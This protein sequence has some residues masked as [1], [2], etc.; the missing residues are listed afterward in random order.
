MST[1]QE[2]HPPSSGRRLAAILFADIVGYTALMQQGEGTAM[3]ILNRFQEVTTAKVKNHQGEII[4]T[5]G[6]G[7]LILFDS[8][9]DAVNC[10]HEMQLVFRQG[11]EV[12]LRI[13]IH[14][15]EVVRKDN[16]VFGNGVNI[17]ARIESMGV[18]GGVLMSSDV[19]R[20]I[21]NQEGLSTQPLGQF[22][23]KNV[24]EPIEVYALTN[25]GMIVPDKNKLPGK[26]KRTMS[27]RLIITSL[28]T[29]FLL[30]S[31]AFWLSNN[32]KVERTVEMSL[33]QESGIASLAVLPFTNMSSGQENQYFCDGLHDDLLTHL[34]QMGNTKVISRTSVLRY[35]D[36]EKPIPEIASQLGV[37]H[38][39][40]GSFR[41][42]DNQIRVNVQL[43]NAQSDDHV[44]SEIYDRELN[45][46][47]VFNIQTE[48]TKKIAAALNANLTEGQ[49]VA[50]EDKPTSSL[51][52]YE[53]YLKGRQIMAKRNTPSLLAAKELFEKA[54]SLDPEYAQAL[55]QLGTVHHLM[56]SYSDGDVEDN[57]NKSI[58][59]LDRGLKLHPNMPEAYALKAIIHES[60]KEFDQAKMAFEKSIQLNPNQAITYHWY[61]LFARDI[62][63]DYEKAKSLLEK[64]RELDPLS[65]AINYTLGR[66]HLGLQEF[67]RG[68][69]FLKK[70]IEIEP[71]YP[72]TYLVL[73][74]LYIA[75]NRLDSAALL[76]Y[77]N[78]KTN[79]NQGI[80]FEHSMF[81]FY[82]LGMDE[83]LL[84]EHDLFKPQ[85][86]Q[87]SIIKYRSKLRT[88]IHIKKDLDQAQ[89]F[90][91]EN[92]FVS[93][94]Q[95]LFLRKEWKAYNQLYEKVY[96]MVISL[97][98]VF[99]PTG[100]TPG[101][102]YYIFQQYLFALK[103]EGRNSEYED[104]W[105]YYHAHVAIDNDRLSWGHLIWKD[106]M[107][108]RRASIQNNKTEAI[109]KLKTIR[110][111]GGFGWTWRLLKMD[112]MLEFIADDE[113]YI[114]IM[115]DW[116][117]L[118]AEQR[119]T[120]R[121]TR[122]EI[123]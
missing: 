117:Q 49:R 29:L 54:I 88:F 9:V 28:L 22:D 101:W 50:V 36:T 15:G 19:Q 68:K 113:S 69:F 53:A 99:A 120:V 94:L 95:I 58:D 43:I 2:N 89:S 92:D 108:L 102:D 76:S 56:I 78:L 10:A 30:A 42:A 12:P 38:I 84:A 13:G 4:K 79:G 40:E 34:S 73:P 116:D 48:V 93:R 37:T 110:Q 77:Q 25:E 118:I 47:S 60:L 64:A 91:N 3:G 98:H 105:K 66:I 74:L 123:H 52:A 80:Y 122:D 6:D 83:E 103:S 111:N 17:A 11:V 121:A 82:Y 44:W 35:R 21:K 100:I 71:S 114:Q 86:R 106:Y 8:S 109:K 26:S 70:T 5:Y 23:F 97:K 18:A 55:V 75:Q 24:E 65:P 31:L 61:S 96:P 45:S 90:V 51:E 112:P 57:R 16:D 7:S 115:D 63:R 14:V 32:S 41:R 81:P 85:N 62:G 67:E 46:E 27:T 119:T 104:L 20:R 72:S 107:L 1:N 33:A 59:Y 87:D 39:L